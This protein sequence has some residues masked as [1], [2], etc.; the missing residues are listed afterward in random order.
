MML[1]EFDL[2]DF[3][4]SPYTKK[5]SDQDYDDDFL[6][7]LQERNARAQFKDVVKNTQLGESLDSWGD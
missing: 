5:K 1:N 2:Q 7:V 4:G 6:T 3:P